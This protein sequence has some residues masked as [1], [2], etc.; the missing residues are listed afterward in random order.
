MERPS[1]RPRGHIRRPCHQ[2]PATLQSQADM[3]PGSLRILPGAPCAPRCW[4]P[5]VPAVA[6]GWGDASPAFGL[7]LPSR[8]Q[9]TL[10]LLDGGQDGRGHAWS[11][12]PSARTASWDPGT[13]CAPRRC[14]APARGAACSAR[15]TPGGGPGLSPGRRPSCRP[16]TRT[17]G[18]SPCALAAG[19]TRGAAPPRL[20]RL[21]C[22]PRSARALR[23][24]GRGG[25]GCRSRGNP[26]CA[27]SRCVAGGCGSRNCALRACGC[28]RL[29]PVSCP[30][31]SHLPGTFP[32]LRFLRSG[33]G[34]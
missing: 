30:P 4:D 28:P 12:E 31:L 27:P 3:H 15:G 10:W 25:S 34:A 9:G 21:R 26:G 14:P 17:P 33:P 16:C 22:F 24:C 8:R 32:P 7:C 6:V 2:P 20:L 18:P 29:G 11:C 5:G 13:C 1:V 23:P 19:R